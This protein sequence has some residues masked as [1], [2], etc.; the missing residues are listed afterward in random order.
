MSDVKR[1]TRG[2]LG[3]QESACGEYVLSRGYDALRAENE[4]LK[5][6]ARNDAVAYK[7]VIDRQE[8]LRAELQ[9]LKGGVVPEAFW[10]V[11]HDTLRGYRMSTLHDSDGDGYPLID[12]MSGDGQTV[13]GGI[14][15]CEYLADATWNAL[16]A[17]APQP[18]DKAQQEGYNDAEISA[19][20]KSR[21]GKTEQT[22]RQ[23][24]VA[25]VTTAYKPGVPEQRELWH[26]E[27]GADQWLKHFQGRGCDTTKIPLYTAPAPGK[28]IE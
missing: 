13:S 9:A 24:P 15:E 14:S 8:E 18:A 6:E 7:A 10:Q 4:R 28:E 21:S 16:L 1:Y 27:D 20:R 22:E 11:I 2:P 17:A 25:W 3:M 26:G 23:E 19:W 12:A 5:R